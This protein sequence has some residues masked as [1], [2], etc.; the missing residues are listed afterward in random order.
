MQGIVSI[1]LTKPEET[2]DLPIEVYQKSY[3]E[4]H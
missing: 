3:K 4:S 1:F 2:V